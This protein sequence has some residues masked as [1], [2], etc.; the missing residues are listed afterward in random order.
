M[1]ALENRQFDQ[2]GVKITSLSNPVRQIAFD[3]IC[4]ITISYH[5]L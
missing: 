2:E 1:G 4:I 3:L 5:W